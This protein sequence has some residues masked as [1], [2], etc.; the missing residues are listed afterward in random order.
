MISFKFQSSGTRSGSKL[1]AQKHN[2]Y[3]VHVMQ[4]SSYSRVENPMSALFWFSGSCLPTVIWTL[5]QD[6]IQSLIETAPKTQ[7]L[8]PIRQH[9]PFQA[10]V[11]LV[12]KGQALKTEWEVHVVQ[13]LIEA[14]PQIQCVEI[15][16]QSEVSQAL[17]ELDRQH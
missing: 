16:W 9:D 10:L 5:L 6:A 12:P 1:G 14:V 13:A 17:I 15:L 4:C 11:K 2:D 8:Q 7:G 3:I